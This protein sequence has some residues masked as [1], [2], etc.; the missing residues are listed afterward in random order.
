MTGAV[1]V[2]YGV[3]ADLIAGHFGGK[4][5]YSKIQSEYDIGIGVFHGFDGEMM[6]VDGQAYQLPGSGVVR[7]VNKDDVTPFACFAK[8]PNPVSHV[9]PK[10]GMNMEEFSKFLEDKYP[11]TSVPLIVKVEGTFQRMRFRSLWGQKSYP[12]TTLSEAAKTQP[13]WT[14]ENVKG[15]VVG[16]RFPSIFSGVQLAGLHIHFM[17]EDKTTGGHVID[18]ETCD[19]LVVSGESTTDFKLTL[20]ENPSANTSA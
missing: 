6:L 20:T 8:M 18:F 7:R 2:Q 17:D 3:A 19:D 10:T 9:V 4:Y 11:N 15:T 5:N 12:Y 16:Y 13:E 14:L 1:I